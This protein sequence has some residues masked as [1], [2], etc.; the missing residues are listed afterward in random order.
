MKGECFVDEVKVIYAG[1][2]TSLALNV[3]IIALPIPSL[4]KL[5]LDFWPRV[6]LI[7]I[8]LLGIM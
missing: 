3:A 7:I 1:T 5:R 6:G 4:R 8:F 2:L